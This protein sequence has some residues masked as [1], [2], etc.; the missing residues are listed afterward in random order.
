MFEDIF[1]GGTGGRGRQRGPQRGYDL[2]T[3]VV[4]S[5]EDVAV[6]VSRTLEFDR[7]DYCGHCSGGGS[8]PGSEP[9]RCTTCAGQGKVQ[10]AV[11]SFF[12]SSVRI[13]VCPQCKG[14]GSLITNPCSKC[15]GTGRQKKRRVLTIQIPA[16]VHE[17]QAVRLRGEG[18]PGQ[19]GAARG[20]LHCYVR[21]KEHPLLQRDGNDLICQVPIGFSQAALGGKI[22]VP[23]LTGPEAVD[24]AAGTQHGEVLTLR[25][26]GLPDVRTGRAGHQLVQV[27]IEVPRKL[28]KRQQQLLREFAETEEANVQPAKKGFLEKLAEYF[29]GPNE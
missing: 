18:E 5:L 24:I 28:D 29:G 22:E 16:G 25:N 17:G 12:G 3:S 7:N 27:V 26:R 21:I 14:R 8:E 2:E 11:Q 6:G 15:K 10:Q 20:D 19:N 4:L 1:G 23:T 9:Q 13:I